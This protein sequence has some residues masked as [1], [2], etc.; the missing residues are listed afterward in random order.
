LTGISP[1]VRLLRTGVT[2]IAN[3]EGKVVRAQAAGQSHPR[4]MVE[5]YVHPCHDMALEVVLDVRQISREI[6]HMV[7]IDE[8]DRADRF[9][10]FT[11]LLSDVV[12]SDE[13]P[14]GFRPVGVLPASNVS[15]EIV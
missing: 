2:E 11:P 13:V 9:L 6:P 12:V 3:V 5:M 15:I 14:Q 1:A 10:V 8:R 7:V 4:R